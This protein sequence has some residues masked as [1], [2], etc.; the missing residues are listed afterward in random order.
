MRRSLT[1]IAAVVTFAARAAAAEVVPVP[2]FR[3]VELRG[4]GSVTV[5]PG[6]VQRVTIVDGSS[7]FNIPPKVTNPTRS[8]CCM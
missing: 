4:G 6:P 2:Q 8:F 5:V 3:S 1:L 7:Q